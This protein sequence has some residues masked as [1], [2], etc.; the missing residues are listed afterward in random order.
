MKK[1][2]KLKTFGLVFILTG[3]LIFIGINSL[4]AKKPVKPE[5]WR[6]KIPISSPYNLYGI[7]IGG[8]GNYENV[9]NIV[10]VR[11]YK[12]RYDGRPYYSFQLILDN[13]WEGECP[14]D[15]KDDVP[16]KYTIGFQNVELAKIYGHPDLTDGKTCY[17]PDCLDV[18]GQEFL[19]SCNHD[20]EVLVMQDFLN[21]NDHPSW[22]ECGFCFRHKVHEKWGYEYVRLTINIFHDIER[23]IPDGTEANVPAG[24]VIKIRTGKTLA[25]TDIF[26][27]DVI[28]VNSNVAS[29]WALVSRSTDGNTWT[30]TFNNQL[31]EFRETYNELVG[32]EPKQ[33]GKSGKWI[34]DSKEFTPLIAETPFSF[35]T[36]WTRVK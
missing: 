14:P 30:I 5:D 15:S 24:V 10:S 22:Y 36:I 26:Y 35:Q 6:V 29:L 25:Q 3:V 31:L 16:G 34:I 27:H 20:D 28:G 2:S 8:N 12:R 1:F 9:D 23:L 7:G 33:R 19:C 17:F 4:E 21:E 13:T 32:D 18:A 11:R